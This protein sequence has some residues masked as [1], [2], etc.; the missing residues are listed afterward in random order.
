[1]PKDLITDAKVRTA[2]PAATPYK[3]GDGGGLFLLVQP[4]G[5]KL[6]RWKFRL[7]GKENVFAIGSYPEIGLAEARSERDAARKLTKL[8]INPA[9]HRKD[10]KK[11][12]I[13]AAAERKRAME[14]SFAKVSAAYLEHV[15]SSYTPGSFRGKESRIRRHLSPKLDAF[16]IAEITAKEIRPVL[17]A[18]KSSGAWA[19]IH[20]KGDLSAI[21]KYAVVRGL[22]DFNPV[23]SLE[24]FLRIPTCQSK[25]V[26]TTNQIKQFYQ[27][28]RSYRGYPE[29]AL[30]LRLIALTACRP[31][32]AAD[33]EWDEFDFTANL[34]R[35]PAEK[36]CGFHAI[37][38]LSPPTS[39]HPFHAHP[40]RQSERSY[41]GS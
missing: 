22:A 21:Y 36:M 5:S 32:E 6:W 8:G 15:R 1:M 17:E 18:C 7:D 25:A 14:S 11:R 28:L 33:A 12:N 37:W 35:R 24:G 9:Q 30:C 19:A 34:W 16:P 26:L 40:D 29:T 39:G 27:A 31:G 38:T 13:D 20:V 2:K 23:P 3:L 4:S 10:G 41:A